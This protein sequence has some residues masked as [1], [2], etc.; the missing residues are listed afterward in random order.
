MI[1]KVPGCAVYSVLL[2][3]CSH[4]RGFIMGIWNSHTSVGN[5]LGSLIAGVYVSSAW[6]LSFIV[7]GIIIACTGVICFFFLVESESHTFYRRGIGIFMHPCCLQRQEQNHN[8]WF[9]FY[10]TWRCE[11]YTT[12][13][14]CEF[15]NNLK[16]NLLLQNI[17]LDIYSMRL[18]AGFT[19]FDLIFILQCD[20]TSCMLLP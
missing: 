20:S 11:L 14:P 5:I 18:Y 6:G 13:T 19:Q 1:V 12:T 10:R 2:M 9:L 3:L 17:W 8:M 16:I 4:R 15:T 7:P